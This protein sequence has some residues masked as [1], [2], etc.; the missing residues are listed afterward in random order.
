[1]V[2][3]SC[4]CKK[5][6]FPYK[7]RPEDPFSLPHI[8]QVVD[9]TSG[10]ET[11][12]FLDAYFGYHQITMKE[13]DQLAT[14]FITPFGSFCYITMSFGLKNA[15]ATYQRCMLKCFRDL[16]RQT[17]EAYVDNIMVKS[18]RADQVVADLEQTFMKLRA[19]NIKPNPEK[20]VFGSQGV[21]CWVLSSPSM[22]SKPTRRRSWPSQGWVQSRI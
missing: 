14:S 1:M 21:R 6:P 19:N 7:A 9:S 2:S 17:V 16:I 4:S 3:Q 20:C 15:G 13:S 11:L 22:A 8:D 10:C 5:D 12:C 18:K